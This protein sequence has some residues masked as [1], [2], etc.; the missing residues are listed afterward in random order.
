MSSAHTNTTLTPCKPLK[1]G[2]P[3]LQI[4]PTSGRIVCGNCERFG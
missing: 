3:W 2:L 1:Y 4:I